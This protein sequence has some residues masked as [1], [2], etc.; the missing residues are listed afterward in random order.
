VAHHL[1][2]VD[3]LVQKMESE[4]AEI[5]AARPQPPEQPEIKLSA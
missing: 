5:D 3:H 2:T 4:L 1:G